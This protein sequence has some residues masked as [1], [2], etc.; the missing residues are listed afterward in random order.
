MLL[1]SRDELRAIT[2]STQQ[3]FQFRDAA[4]RGYVP[5]SSNDAMSPEFMCGSLVIAHGKPG[6]GGAVTY[7]LVVAGEQYRR[8]WRGDRARLAFVGLCTSASGVLNEVYFRDWVLTW[9]EDSALPQRCPNSS[10]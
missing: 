3:W 7:R 10:A 2:E 5:I 9:L 6:R 8:V 1:W 4:A